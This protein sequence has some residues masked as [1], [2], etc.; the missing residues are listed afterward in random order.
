[1]RF[2]KTYYPNANAYNLG[3]MFD[4]NNDLLPEEEWS[5]SIIEPIFDFV[6]SSIQGDQKTYD[7]F[8]HSAGAQFA[9]R[10]LTYKDETRANR[11]VAANAGWYTLP[12]T[13]I[14]FP[15]GLKNSM[16]DSMDIARIAQKNLIVQLGEADTLR[17]DNLRKTPEA[18]AQGLNRLAR[19]QSYF[20]AGKLAAEEL[21][22]PFNWR[23]VFVPGVGH[24]NGSMAPNAAKILFE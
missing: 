9:P 3:W 22:V 13:N 21:G 12:D 10:F 23:L 15:Y 14:D 1:M 17:S 19:G 8:G 6:V 5:Y 16:A 24:S 18:D 4:E 2:S 11:V 20:E 7:I